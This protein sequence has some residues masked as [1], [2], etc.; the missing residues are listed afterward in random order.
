M[1]QPKQ[2][3][4]LSRNDRSKSINRPNKKTHKTK[5]RYLFC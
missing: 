5:N 1:P 4:S 3:H 2:D